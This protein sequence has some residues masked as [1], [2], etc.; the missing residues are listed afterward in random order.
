M[1]SILTIISING[2]VNSIIVWTGTH[3]SGATMENDYVTSWPKIQQTHMYNGQQ[4]SAEQRLATARS[5]VGS[6]CSSGG[7]SSG[8]LVSLEVSDITHCDSVARGTICA[9][10]L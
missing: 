9:N 3:R 4:S 5:E 6:T 8:L 2:T 1:H 7:I 10:L